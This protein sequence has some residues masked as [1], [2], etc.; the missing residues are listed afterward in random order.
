MCPPDHDVL[1]R[2]TV[3][4]NGIAERSHAGALLVDRLLNACMLSIHAA[5]ADQ[6]HQHDQNYDAIEFT[7]MNGRRLRK[8]TC[9][10]DTYL[11]QATK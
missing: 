9:G 3:F 7:E 2:R 1:F 8:R 10:Y 6:T 11:I 5:R 4:Q